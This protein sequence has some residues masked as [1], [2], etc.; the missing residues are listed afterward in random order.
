MKRKRRKI[1]DPLAGL[2]PPKKI[3]RIK[4]AVEAV[5][6]TNKPARTTPRPKYREDKKTT[7]SNED[8]VGRAMD[9]FKKELIKQS[10]PK[11]KGRGKVYV[12][13]KRF[14]CD[15]CGGSGS[16]ANNKVELPKPVGPKPPKPV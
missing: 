16:R 13:K 9:K 10:C 2:L 15:A 7:E 14:K 8:R 1:L 11:C 5:H 4:E 6:E 3:R 12:G